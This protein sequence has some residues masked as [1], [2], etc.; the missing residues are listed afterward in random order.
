MDDVSFADHSTV[1]SIPER[2]SES[3]YSI[4]AAHRFNSTEVDMESLDASPHPASAPSIVKSEPASPGQLRSA[5]S[6]STSHVASQM[7]TQKHPQSHPQANFSALSQ[8]NGLHSQVRSSTSTSS[9][10]ASTSAQPAPPD[11]VA[12]YPAKQSQQQPP[13][14]TTMTSR[15][16]ITPPIPDANA[17]AMA[18]QSP[19]SVPVPSQV[20]RPRKSPTP[21]SQQPS[22]PHSTASLHNGVA[23]PVAAESLKPQTP[24]FAPIGAEMLPEYAKQRLK[25]ECFRSTQRVLPNVR[26]TCAQLRHASTALEEPTKLFLWFQLAFEY[27]PDTLTAQKDVWLIC[28]YFHFVQ[29]TSLSNVL[30]R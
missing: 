3:T 18:R 12:P 6:P 29:S 10:L 30:S 2:P 13:P 9:T 5:V 4:G 25:C 15:P 20:L 11:A 19:R 1:A 16:L 28:K 21:T 24:K 8:S 14:T 23:Q 26:G 27:S 7:P 17:L 22:Q